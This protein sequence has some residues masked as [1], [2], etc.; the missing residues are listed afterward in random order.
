MVALIIY[1]A[2][3]A[4]GVGA[5]GFLG[6]LIVMTIMSGFTEGMADLLSVVCWLIVMAASSA[7]VVRGVARR[8]EGHLGEALGVLAMLAVPAV[9]AIAFILG[10]AFLFIHTT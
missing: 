10:T 9:L 7:L 2:L 5:V 3:L 4:V 6:L 8:R 1:W